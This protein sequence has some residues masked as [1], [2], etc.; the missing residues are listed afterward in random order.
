M[1]IIKDYFLLLAFFAFVFFQPAAVFAGDYAKLNVIGFSKDGRYL[2]FEEFGTQDGSGFPYSNVYFVET[3][4]NSYAAAPVKVR[5]DNEAATEGAARLKAKNSAAANLKKFK[6]I[7]GNTGETVVSRLITDLN[8]DRIEVGSDKKN[9]IVK[10][11]DY[12]ASSYFTDEFELVL[13]TSEVKI[14][15]CDYSDL[16]VLKFDLTLRNVRN[17]TEK[18]LQSDKSLPESR[19]CPLAYS[20]QN[21]YVYENR[22]AVFLN[23]YSTGFEG[24]D[25]RFMTVTGVY[26]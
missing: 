5:L 19:S 13:Q 26:K 11:T 4:K 3:A 18:L 24:P 25:M 17:D 14:K 22:I 8:A 20:I 1:K 15:A 9:Q 2:A 7:A 21:V 10:F 16:P 23:V 12:R 6:I